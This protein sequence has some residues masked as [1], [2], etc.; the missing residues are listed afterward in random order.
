MRQKDPDTNNRH[1]NNMPT[2]QTRRPILRGTHRGMHPLRRH[3]QARS[4]RKT[5]LHTGQTPTPQP[6]HLPSLPPR[7]P[8]PHNAG[9]DQ[10]SVREREKSP[11]LPQSWET[12]RAEQSPEPSQAPSAQR[13]RQV[14]IPENS[15]DNPHPVPRGPGEVGSRASPLHDP[16]SSLSDS[17]CA[18]SC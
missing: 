3:T 6:C 1:R 4:H 5:H 12:T 11:E 14:L 13:R 8:S 18:P 15:Q 2:R 17:I 7:H 16:F 9:L 10:I